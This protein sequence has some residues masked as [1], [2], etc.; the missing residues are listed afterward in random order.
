MKNF[1]R[2][3][4]EKTDGSSLS[5]RQSVNLD[6]APSQEVT[7][8]RL[9]STPNSF[10]GVEVHN[11]HTHHEIGQGVPRTHSVYSTSSI[12]SY[13]GT[14]SAVTTPPT[15]YTVSTQHT[16]GFEGL[17]LVD[18]TSNSTGLQHQNI[19]DVQGDTGGD[20]EE[21]DLED[22]LRQFNR[23]GALEAL[24]NKQ[25][26]EAEDYIKEV[27]DDLTSR[28]SEDDRADWVLKLAEVQ[29]LQNAWDSSFET[30]RAINL[31]KLSSLYLSSKVRLLMA[32]AAARIEKKEIAK[33]QCVKII[34]TCRNDVQ[35][36]PFLT[37]GIQLMTFILTQEGN[38]KE[39][40]FY[41]SLLPKQTIEEPQSALPPLPYHSTLPSSGERRESNVHA[42]PDVNIHSKESIDPRAQELSPSDSAS[43]LY[44]PPD[45]SLTHT[46][47]PPAIPRADSFTLGS[48]ID[49][50]TIIDKP[51]D[52]RIPHGHSID[53]YNPNRQNQNVYAPGRGPPNARA[54]SY[55]GPPAYLPTS[56]A[57]RSH[58]M[59]ISP[60]EAS[61]ISIPNSPSEPPKV[62]AVDNDEQYSTLELVDPTMSHFS[63]A[64]HQYITAKTYAPTKQQSVADADLLRE[65]GLSFGN[66]NEE[67]EGKRADIWRAIM[68]AIESDNNPHLAQVLF[69]GDLFI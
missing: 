69:R 39:A 7:R 16:F 62:Y 36:R 65:F 23:D 33:L 40:K 56:I 63:P 27:I 17:K 67:I 60:A 29:Q 13:T 28:D 24:K 9:A 54:L 66:S 2:R 38:T 20:P 31:D 47:A 57:Q 25:W 51:A 64:Q 22:R 48:D 21:D 18:N 11:H 43:Q 52:N 53:Q 50:R 55:S 6:K 30:V 8:P 10:P 59:A 58:S 12:S 61:S 37:G 5:S 46:L 35:L 32:E 45:R 26:S 4:K 19:P 15:P 3:P 41:Q 1:L 14:R 34:K 42:Q 44:S 68:A 49:P